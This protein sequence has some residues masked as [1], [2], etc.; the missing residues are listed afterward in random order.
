MSRFND[1]IVFTNSKCVGCNK[2]KTVCPSFGANVTTFS[3]GRAQVAVSKKCIECGRCVNACVHHAREF[4]DDHERF[5]EALENGEKISLLIDPAF[6]LD[7]GEKSQEILGFLKE[8]GVNEIY[9]VAYGAEISAY[10]HVKYIKENSDENGVCKS[11]VANFCPA[12]TNYAEKLHPN[13]IPLLIPVQSPVICTA[14][15][16]KKYL[17]DNSKLAYISPCITQTGEIFS[18]DNSQEIS[19]NVTFAGLSKYI[20]RRELSGAKA[21]SVLKSHGP[22]NLIPHPQGFL[23]ILS[24]YFSREDVLSNYTGVS[25]STL[26]FLNAASLS[27]TISHPSIITVSACTDGCMMGSGVRYRDV[28]SIGAL[29]E[30]KAVRKSCFAEAS[31]CADCD[32]YFEK[33]SEKYAE[34]DMQDFSR[35]YHD[36]YRQQYQVPDDAIND[37]FVSMHKETEVKRTLNCQS[38]G[39]KSCREMAIAVAN[40]YARIQDCIHYMNDDLQFTALMDR[41]TGILNQNGFRRKAGELLE[42]NPE[43]NYVLFVGNV[44][45]LKNV[46][47]FYGSEMG[48]KILCYIATWL[49]EKTQDIGICARFGGGVFA[50][51]IE[52]KPEFIESFTR[53]ESIDSRHLGVY[54]PITIRYG[55][56]RVSDHSIKVGDVSN[57]CTYA[58]DKATNRTQNSYIEFDETMRKEM[59]IETD[60]TLKMRDAMDNGEFVL[61]L[62]PQYD[63][64]TGKIVGAEALSRWIQTD[65]S[66]VSPGLFIPVFEKN[67]FI[68]DMDRYVWESAFKLVQQWEK[69]GE[70]MVPIS[71]NISRVSLETD[72]IIDVIGKLATRYPIDKKHLYFEITESAYMKDQYKLTERI[73]MLRSLGFEIAMDD[74]GSGYSSLNSLKDIPLDVLKLDM[75]FLRGGTNLE[76]GNEIIAHVVDMAKALELKIVGEGVETKAQADFLTEKGCDVIQGYYYAK[77]MTLTDYAAKLKE[78]L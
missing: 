73:R 15:Y 25:E 74:F 62:Q 20:K 35:V 53:Y 68:K 24:L 50:A 8:L 12:M 57:F 1:G 17:K 40:G 67:G 19:Y 10:A 72:E 47:D 18:L 49:T 3:E 60:I 21:E 16:V 38:C 44:N 5:F 58:A 2:C 33:M 30:Y 77:P 32:E 41:M 59:Q 52:D 78:D 26:Q 51:F 7:Y 55:M 4:N 11:F 22:G 66:I 64:K 46:N 37:I 70:P 14:I 9:D 13:L 63:H 54:F 56:Y 29:D 76:R 61:Y 31:A 6:Y 34:L 69:S 71:V 39:Y 28:Q 23:D 36:N 75:G 43:K 65:G 27:E 42:E 45:K 48:D